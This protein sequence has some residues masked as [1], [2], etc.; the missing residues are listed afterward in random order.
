LGREGD[1]NHCS[2]RCSRCKRVNTSGGFLKPALITE[3]YLPDVGKEDRD[4][5]LRGSSTDLTRKE[6]FMDWGGGCRGRWG[7]VRQNH[8]KDGMSKVGVVAIA[9]GEATRSLGV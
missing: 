1:E 2:K 8:R 6:F 7:V 4:C 3:N 5:G 9:S